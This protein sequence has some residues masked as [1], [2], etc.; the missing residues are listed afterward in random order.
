MLSRI[1]L[2]IPLVMLGTATAARAA[3]PAVEA[4]AS[5]SNATTGDATDAPAPAWNG[6]LPLWEH[7]G[8]VEESG[9]AQVGWARADVGVGPLTIGTQPFLDLFGTWN[10]TGKLGLVRKGRL[11]LALDTGW[12]RVPTA[13]QSRGLGNLH[14]GAFSNPYAPVTLVPM[15]LAATYL[16][17][18]RLHVHA[19]ATVVKTLSDAPELTTLTAGLAGWVEWFASEHRSVRLHAGVDAYPTDPQAH[20]GIS[21]GWRYRHVALQAGYARRFAADGTSD[22]AIMFDTALLFP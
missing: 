14:A 5:P 20:L 10:L 19:S 6:V 15:A 2:F 13:A 18:P 22:G 3:A 9:A 4:A 17:K 11:R 7:T 16:V 8:V 12:Y 21:F 1:W